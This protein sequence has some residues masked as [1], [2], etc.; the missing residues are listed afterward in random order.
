MASQ[1]LESKTKPTNNIK[2]IQDKRHQ[3]MDDVS[4][5]DSERSPITAV[6]KENHEEQ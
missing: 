2:S 4:N 5:E 6:A 1:R 3:R